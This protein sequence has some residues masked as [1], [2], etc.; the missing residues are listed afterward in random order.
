M[1]EARKMDSDP[2]DE[3]SSY[4]RK[5]IEKLLNDIQRL[6]LWDYSFLLNVKILEKIELVIACKTQAKRIT[7]L[8]S[9]LTLRE[10][11]A[12]KLRTDIEKQRPLI[13]DVESHFKIDDYPQLKR[14]RK[15][16]DLLFHP[17]TNVSNSN[18]RQRT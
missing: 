13:Q 17:Q 2:I 7:A 14:L 12:R 11:D 10:G 16:I 15:T 3:D 1:K 4:N 9:T 8:K 6:G 18:K 5:T